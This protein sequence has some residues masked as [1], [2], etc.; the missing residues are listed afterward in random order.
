MPDAYATIV[1]VD[2]ATQER[3]ADVLELRAADPQQ[4]AILESYLSEVE[5]GPETRVLEIG[6]GTGAVTRAL[7]GR[8]GVAA[9][10][11]VDPSPVFL[12]RARELAAGRTNLTFEQGDGRS[13]RFADGDFDVVVLH[14][15]LC[16]VPEP[17]LVLA[18]AWRVLRAGGSL[19]VCD[20]DYAT[21]T[22]AL[23]D[24]DPRAPL[25]VS[26]QR[27]AWVLSPRLLPLAKI[28]ERLIEL[29]NA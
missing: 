22:V 19:A 27:A 14:T 8:A 28:V 2:V 18:E 3:L 10:V 29:A 17:E 20:G 21:V 26:W 9:A 1:D 16:H 13:L 12:A 24:W 4:R 5:F 6:C 15:T 25:P 23:G 7:A 11:G